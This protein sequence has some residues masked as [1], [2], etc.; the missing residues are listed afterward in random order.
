MGEYPA[1][2]TRG[3]GNR[4][5][6]Q[7]YDNDSKMMVTCVDITAHVDPDTTPNE[8]RYL[9]VTATKKRTEHSIRP[10]SSALFCHWYDNFK[11]N[12]V[13]TLKADW[14]ICS[15]TCLACSLILTGLLYGERQVPVTNKRTTFKRHRFGGAVLLFG[16]RVI[17]WVPELPCMFRLDPW[18]AKSVGTT[19][20]NNMYVFFGAPRAQNL[21]LWM[22]TTILTMQTS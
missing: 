9:A 1:G 5:E 21:C 3:T 19:F 17:F 13:R 16:G 8:D 10:V 14:S 7:G 2:N 11:A 15:Y 6:C 22:T 12:R 18:Q 20:W 4:P